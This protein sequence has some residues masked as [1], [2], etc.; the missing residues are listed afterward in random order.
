M[1]II[2]PVAAEVPMAGHGELSHFDP[3]PIDAACRGKDVL[4]EFEQEL[5]AIA[6]PAQRSSILPRTQAPP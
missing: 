6:R 1:E 2:S 3:T 4:T 5:R